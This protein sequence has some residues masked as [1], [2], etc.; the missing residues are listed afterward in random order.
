MTKE[1]Q[2]LADICVKGVVTVTDEFVC[3]GAA[4]LKP[5][6]QQRD[7]ETGQQQTL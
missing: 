4:L 1:R 7:A 5:V 2:I 6:E 3:D